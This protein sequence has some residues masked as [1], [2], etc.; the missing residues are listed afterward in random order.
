MGSPR[1]PLFFCNWSTMSPHHP[2]SPVT[3]GVARVPAFGSRRQPSAHPYLILPGTDRCGARAM[4]SIRRPENIDHWEG[5]VGAWVQFVRGGFDVYREYMN[6]PAML[7]R[8]GAV[9][10]L[11]V[12]DLGCGEGYYSRT[13]AR[14]GARVTALAATP[15]MIAQAQ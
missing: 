9:R 12:L 6:S 2:E 5:I 10:G 3:G 14:R 1:V 13:L 8:I 4:P 7:R 11:D 15:A